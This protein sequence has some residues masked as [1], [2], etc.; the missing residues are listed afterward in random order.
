MGEELNVNLHFNQKDPLNTLGLVVDVSDTFRLGLKLDSLTYMKE[1]EW[2]N[3]EMVDTAEER[4]KYV[5]L[6]IYKNE[7]GDFVYANRNYNVLL[8][9][10][11]TLGANETTDTGLDLSGLIGAFLDNVLL[12][13]GV[14]YT[15]ST[16]I[17]YKVEGNIDIIDMAQAELKVTI[18]NKANND[19][20]IRILYL[21]VEDTLYIDLECL[22]NMGFASLGKL[23][24][25]KYENMGLRDTLAGLDIASIVADLLVNQDTGLQNSITIDTSD[26]NFL[27]NAK[28]GLY[29]YLIVNEYLSSGVLIGGEEIGTA[30]FNAA[31]NAD[32][33]GTGGEGTDGEGTE[34]ETTEGG[35]LDIMQILGMALKEVE[36]DAIKSTLTIYVATGVLSSLLTM[37]LAPVD[38]FGNPVD[39]TMPNV[40]AFVQI[41]ALDFDFGTDEEGKNT[42]FP[43][44]GYLRIYLSL[45]DDGDQT[46]EAISLEIDI[47]K[48]ITVRSGKE[49]LYRD[50]EEEEYIQSFVS[51]PEFL[52]KLAIGIRLEGHFDLTVDETPVFEVDEN[53]N[54]VLDEDGNKIPVLDED[55]NQVMQTIEQYTNA[56]L[57]QMLSGLIEGLGLMVDTSKLNIEL[58]F[59]IAGKISLGGIIKLDGSESAD[60]INTI[61]AGS[62]LQIRLFDRKVPGEAGDI[63]GIYLLD[64]NLYIDLSF[65]GMPN[66]GINNVASLIEDLG[67]LTGSTEADKDEAPAN[68]LH[69]DRVA[70]FADASNPEA[71]ALQVLLD[72]DKV[73]IN[74]TK[75]AI[76]G[77]ISLLLSSELPIEIQETSL[78]LG[79]NNN[80]VYLEVATGV[81]IFNL[82]LG[83]SKFKIALDGEELE[84]AEYLVSLP[85]EDFY[86]TEQGLPTNVYLELG[87]YAFINSEM[88]ENSDRNTIDLSPA[89]S[90]LLDGVE[91]NM[92]IEF[93]GL[94]DEALFFE[95]DAN[96]NLE[97]IIGILN[98]GFD[99]AKLQQTGL[100]ITL[101]T[102]ASN[103]STSDDYYDENGDRA[104][105]PVMEIYY[106]EGDLYAHIETFIAK[107]EYIY[108]PGA[109]ELL[110]GLLGAMMGGGE[111]GNA[112]N[113]E[114]PVEVNEVKFYIDLA[115]A[116]YGLAV[117][118][119]KGFLVGV[120]NVLGLN[121]EEY[122][123]SLDLEVELGLNASP[124]EVFLALKLRDVGMDGEDAPGTANPN[125]GNFV[126]LGA[127]I[128]KLVI[129]MD[130]IVEL[131]DEEKQKYDAIE[132]L[133]T[134]GI[135][136]GGVA[137]FEIT[138]PEGVVD[139]DTGAI[140]NITS[141][142]NILTELQTILG[143]N[144]EKEKLL[145]IREAA[146]KPE[147]KGLGDDELSKIY[148]E[149]VVSNI[150]YQALLNFGLIVEVIGNVANGTATFGGDVYYDI[151]V[152]LDISNISNLKASVFLSTTPLAENRGDIMWVSIMGE[153]VLNAE[154][155]ETS[156]DL[157]VVADLTRVFGDVLEIKDV[158]RINNFNAFT[159]YM[160]NFAEIMTGKEETIDPVALNSTNNG[161]VLPEMQKE[162]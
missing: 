151:E 57:N 158:I 93:L 37:L 126:S 44:N 86:L 104:L 41:K 102:Y 144:A 58:G 127:S 106:V 3:Y 17:A 141:L 13:I 160:D 65:F 35:G 15:G 2:E 99:I 129:L 114:D 111:E 77:L 49:N 88:V 92:L 140:G 153:E 70:E 76:A 81:E 40:N 69:L 139:P 23:P 155:G 124:L 5:N 119:T 72:Y 125:D 31:L 134:I 117:N 67:T 142:S 157:N 68:L 147:Y 108:I 137:K 162:R 45:L 6:S 52:D 4:S 32:G 25:L 115:L 159:E 9:G 97:E 30:L 26:P 122:L 110:A 128:N 85:D 64:G 61:L 34:G 18:Y 132:E 146:L 73:A 63:L 62:A 56:Y 113:A 59:E 11:V 48:D 143:E 80:G 136:L 78:E 130:E 54:Y 43:E 22:K 96:L 42:I 107:L 112:Y 133:D 53:G 1:P 145:W 150:D 33:D 154:T 105:R 138:S 120:L 16:T 98:N 131:S 27:N 161:L 24:R 46:I 156:I 14:E 116:D 84:G 8:Q 75:D 39:I 118:I 90:G 91:L 50:I 149:E 36:I 66:I 123:K 100:V 121:I 83:L 109:N 101:S 152:I 51:I 82:N 135:N 60:P 74:L 71:V 79:L 95:L 103:D 38:E 55:G 20:F 89:L 10:D 47:L 29:Q 7:N 19:P 87:G 28:L 21:G 12:S 94:V 148:D